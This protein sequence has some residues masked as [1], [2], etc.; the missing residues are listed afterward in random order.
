MTVAIAAATND[1]NTHGLRSTFYLGT[2]RPPSEGSRG[3][4]PDILASQEM[5]GV[6][7]T[8][9]RLACRISGRHGLGMHFQS[10]PEWATNAKLRA[11]WRTLDRPAA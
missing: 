9:R 2:H 3:R 6:V 10:C 7:K 1:A 8:L 11:Y 5:G 4:D